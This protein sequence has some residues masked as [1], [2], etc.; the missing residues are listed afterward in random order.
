MTEMVE[1]PRNPTHFKIDQLSPAA[2]EQLASLP[3]SMTI[4]RLG[5]GKVLFPEEFPEIHELVLHGFLEYVLPEHRWLMDGE[6]VHLVRT[7]LGYEASEHVRCG[8]YQHH[9][10]LYE[11]RAAR[12]AALEANP[13]WCAF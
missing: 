10:K 13:L 5:Y 8:L 9:K 11:D 6:K 4:T 3:E 2:M 7:F 1:L 12:D